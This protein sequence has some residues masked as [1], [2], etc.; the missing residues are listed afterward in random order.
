MKQA[1]DIINRVIEKALV[2]IFALLVLDVLWQVFARYVLADSPSFTEEF[3]RFS[4][5]W[6]SIL[7]MA[8]LSGQREHLTMDFIYRK[9]SDRLQRRVSILIEVLVIIFAIAV[10]IVGGLNLVYTTL[11][12]H[13][14]SSALHIPLGYVYAIVPISGILIVFYSLYHMTTDSVVPTTELS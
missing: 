6:M 11:T 12:L 10:M 8:Y 13:Q 9:M 5:I 4:L 14:E 3:A 2:L 7:G 1:F